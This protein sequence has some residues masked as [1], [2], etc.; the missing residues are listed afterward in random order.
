MKFIIF[1]LTLIVYINSE[2]KSKLKKNLQNITNHPITIKNRTLSEN[3]LDFGDILTGISSFNQDMTS[4]NDN[5]SKMSRYD[6]SYFINNI[7]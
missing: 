3:K 4:T 1:V 5:S 2:T 7:R 6:S